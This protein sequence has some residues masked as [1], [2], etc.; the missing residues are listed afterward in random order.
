MIKILKILLLMCF[1]IVATGVAV[2]VVNA[3]EAQ[4]DP[5]EDETAQDTN[6]DA[7]TEEQEPEYELVFSDSLRIIE[8]GWDGK[9]YW[10][11]V[12]GDRSSTVLVTD[13]G[14]TVDGG[15]YVDLQPESYKIAREGT[16]RIEYTVVEDR[17]VVL[18]ADGRVIANGYNDGVQAVPEGNYTMQSIGITAVLAFTAI[19][20][21]VL[22]ISRVRKTQTKQVT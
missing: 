13:G 6:E 14:R 16:T 22:W 8:S 12:E 11:D 18:S 2:D 17:R 3:Q 20:A 21:N 10:A 7:Q 5:E 19:L 9:T 4:I 15:N 1:L